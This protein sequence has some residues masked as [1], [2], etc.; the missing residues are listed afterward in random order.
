MTTPG[1]LTAA[2]LGM[3]CCVGV[4]ISPCTCL[5]SLLLHL[6][7]TNGPQSPDVFVCLFVFADLKKRQFSFV[8]ICMGSKTDVTPEMTATGLT[9]VETFDLCEA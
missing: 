7:R 4:L 6:V 8:K 2:T 9:F 3:C 5:L 1:Y